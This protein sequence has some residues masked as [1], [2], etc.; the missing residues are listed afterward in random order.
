MQH[1]LSPSRQRVL[2]VCR[3]R[4]AR[5]PVAKHPALRIQ[6]GLEGYRDYLFGA[7]AGPNLSSVNLFHELAHAAEF[8]PELFRYRA[9]EGGFQF[10]VPRRFIYDRYCAEPRTDGATDRELRTFAYQLH[11]M[12]AAG[13]KQAEKPFF[14]YGAKVMRFMHDWWHVPGDDDEGRARHCAARIEQCYQELDAKVVL[15]RLEGWLDATARRWHRLKKKP[16]DFGGYAV[17]A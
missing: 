14:D 2:A 15:D 13:C 10:K 12:H 7:R 9:M 16:E 1:T 11:L 3:A 17:L 8:G 6:P 5:L 4:L